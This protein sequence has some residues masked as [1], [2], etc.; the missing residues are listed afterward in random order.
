MSMHRTI[1]ISLAC[2]MVSAGAIAKTPESKS[3]HHSSHF[4]S[5]KVAN[6]VERSHEGRTAL[7]GADHIRSHGRP[8]QN[9]YADAPSSEG[10]GGLADAYTGPVHPVGQM[11]VGT[12]AW[13]DWVGSRTASG[14]ILD[15]VTATAAHRSLPL[16]SYAKVTNLDTGRSVIVKINDRG[17]GRRRFIIDLS[18]RAAK[19]IDIIRTGIAA[20]IV[21][22]VS[23]GA[24]PAG[25]AA[26]KVAVFQSSGTAAI[27]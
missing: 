1:G 27:Q 15:S 14:E 19:A 5:A 17:P 11:Q 21:E 3:S 12:A 8:E 25:G 4:Q 16:L 9:S 23:I 10:G 18:P 6:S 2:L 13:Y 7:C 22:P 20:V 26:P 24:G